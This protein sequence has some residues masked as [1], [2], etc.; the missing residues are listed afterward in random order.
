MEDFEAFRGNRGTPAH[1]V[2]LSK[3]PS[4]ICLQRELPCI[5]RTKV[6]LGWRSTALE[7]VERRGRYAKFFGVD[8]RALLQLNN[9]C[10]VAVLGGRKGSVE[11]GPCVIHDRGSVSKFHSTRRNPLRP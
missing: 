2:T 10:T 9:I 6:H 4:L 1:C 3:T 8:R 5:S 7:D 11:K